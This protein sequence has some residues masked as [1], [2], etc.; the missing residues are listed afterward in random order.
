MGHSST[1][2]IPAQGQG[3]I[4]GKRDTIFAQI[5]GGI[6]DVGGD[7]VRDK[8]N[9]EGANEINNNDETRRGEEK[10]D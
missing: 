1:R 7:G 3:L 4:D 2:S 9:N 6:D 10:N 8:S 5:D